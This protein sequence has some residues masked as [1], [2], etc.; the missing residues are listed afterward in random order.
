MSF[1]ELDAYIREHEQKDVFSGVVLIAKDGE[2]VFKEAYG[3]ADRTFNTSNKTDTK[4]NIGSLN[5]MFTELAI[6]QLME[7]ELLQKNT[8]IKGYLPDLPERLTEKI[9]IN[10]ILNHTSGL[11]HYWNQK[12]QSSLSMLRTVDDF[13][14]LFINDPLSFE[15][16][17]RF[18]Y[19]NSGFCL[20]GKIIENTT[21]I[22]YYRY[23]RDNIYSPIGMNNSDH[24]E[25]DTPVINKATGYSKLDSTGHK[26]DTWKSNVFMIGV[27]GS[28]AGGGFSTVDDLLRFRNAVYYQRINCPSFL[29]YFVSPKRKDDSSLF[30]SR[31]GGA[32]GIAALFENTV[33]KR[34]TVIVLSNIDPVDV[35][36]RKIVSIHDKIKEMVLGKAF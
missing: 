29:D 33:D 32:P 4:F 26:Q 10:H 16:G 20:L 19:S 28:P 22:D 9:T 34:Y 14:E 6:H 27:K 13:V 12:F 24:F 11:G 21:G 2:T 3:P 23:V 7:K 31:A 35:V 15:P 36:T 1:A 30:I 17:E 5:K 25:L 18:Q 8:P